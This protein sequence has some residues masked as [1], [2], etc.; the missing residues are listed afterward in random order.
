M[1]AQVFCKQWAEGHQDVALKAEMERRGTS[2]SLCLPRRPPR[3]KKVGLW[4]HT[5]G[6]VTLGMWLASSGPQASHL[7]NRT[8]ALNELWRGLRHQLGHPERGGAAS[9]QLPFLAQA[10]LVREEC[11]RTSLTVLMVVTDR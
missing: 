2:L 7:E 5:T 1:R 3:W 11:P 4:S 6:C 10:Q 8:N 9:G